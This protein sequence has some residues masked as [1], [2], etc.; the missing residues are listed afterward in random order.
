MKR[1]YIDL[2]FKT[3]TNGA[4]N[5]E[6]FKFVDP[7]TKRDDAKDTTLFDGNKWKREISHEQQRD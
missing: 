7:N 3:I 1:R 2:V 6:N 5:W 4:R